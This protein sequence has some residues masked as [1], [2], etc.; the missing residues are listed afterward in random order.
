LPKIKVG[1][2]ACLLGQPVRYDGQSKKHLLIEE[3]IAA[4]VE[5][6]P[7]CPEVGSGMGVPREKIQLVRINEQIRVRHV[8]QPEKDVTAQLSEYARQVQQEFPDLAALILKSKSP[9]CGLHSTPIF[10]NGREIK[11]GA[12]QFAYLFKDYNKKSKIKIL[13]IEETTLTNKENCMEFLTQLG[14]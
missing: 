13:M 5:L 3:Y 10:E 8:L 9:S 6:I 2:S 12:G 7:I 1:I 11:T 14:L 4:H